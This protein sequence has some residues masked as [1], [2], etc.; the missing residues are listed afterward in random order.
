M[1]VGKIV[2]IIA[3]ILMVI[4]GM[5]CMLAPGMTYLSLAWIVGV[6]MIVEGVST[7]VAFFAARE[8]RD[9]DGWD[10]LSGIFS[11]IFGIILVGSN[12]MQLLADALILQIVSAWIVIRGVI[13]IA[14]ALRIRKLGKEMDNED[15]FGRRW[16]VLLVLGVLMIVVGIL[17]FAH[18]VA[19]AIAIGFYIGFAMCAAGAD[20]VLLGLAL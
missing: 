19:L 7:I 3:G 8:V 1:T 13:R 12:L 9:V 10:M 20:L 5:A 6:L 15:G 4:G 18:P 16:W 2:A 17:C 11:L 14:A